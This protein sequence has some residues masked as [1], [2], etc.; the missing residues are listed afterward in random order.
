MDIEKYK[1]IFL[2]E[3]GKY[4]HELETTLIRVEKDLLNQDLW[5]DIHGKIHC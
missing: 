5:G 1:K 2:Q 4:L 3:S